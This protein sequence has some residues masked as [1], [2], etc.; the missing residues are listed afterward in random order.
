MQTRTDLALEQ[1]GNVNGGED[2]VLRRRGKAFRIT[3]IIIDSD[4]HGAAIGRG[5]G[6]YLTLESERLSQFSNA[7]R[8]QVEELAAEL[9]QFL[10]EGE[11]LVAGL[12]NSDIT[13]DSLG[14]AVANKLLATRHLRTELANDTPDAE[15]LHSLRPVSVLAHGVLGQTGIETAELIDALRNTVHPQ[16][17]VAIDALACS[18]LH[19][20]GT[21][22][23]ISDAGISPGS[24]VRNSRKELSE[25]TLGVPVIAI[26][27]PT[28]V[29]MHTIVAH[30]TGTDAP[31]G[32]AGLPNMMVTPRD[33]DKLLFRAAAMIAAALNL[34]LHPQLGF[35][36]VEGLG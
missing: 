21:T 2:I 24:G 14:P 34:A 1:A 33:I 4:A 16:A 35:E 31:D 18:D 3:E 27:V 13:P 20:L 6:R 29:D 10:P 5:K 12:G 15:F 19:R 22:I 11:I 26:G 36:D 25:R 28:V 8:E 17:V 9:R 7:Y 32:Q 30:Y 23:Q